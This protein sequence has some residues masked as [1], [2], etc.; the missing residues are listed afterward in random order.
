MD[1][2]SSIPIIS[3]ALYS[4]F[5]SCMSSEIFELTAQGD[6]RYFVHKDILARQSQPF[7]DATNGVWK[8]STDRQINL[9]DWDAK[10]VGRLVQ[11][12]YT[13]DYKYTTSDTEE[14]GEQPASVSPAISE[15]SELGAWPSRAPPRITDGTWL[16]RVDTSTFDF[17]ETLLAHAMVYS[18]AHY[19]AITALKALAQ[20][21]LLRVLVALHPMAGN[22]HLATNIVHL[23]TYVYGNTD[24]LTNS[25][26]PLRNM[27]TNYVVLNFPA[28]QAYPAAVEMMCG[29]GDFVR[30]VLA[31]ICKQLGSPIGLVM[32][33]PA[34]RFVTSIVWRPAKGNNT[35]PDPY[36]PELDSRTGEVKDG[37]SIGWLYP[38]FAVGHQTAV[39][40]FYLNQSGGISLAT[41][42]GMSC[43][44]SCHINR[45]VS[46]DAREGIVALAFVRCPDGVINM[47]RFRDYNGVLSHVDH[48]GNDAKTFYLLWKVARR[49]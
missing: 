11:F 18:L 22:P 47:G 13:G 19:K 8:E 23:A 7:T 30:D 37:D 45:G 44:S 38:V 3:N 40:H 1:K 17:E 49:V 21:R 32:A 9:R 25:A 48:G 24:S 15:L 35:R 33:T 29:G 2:Q 36:V 12:L 4:A 42:L 34:T 14:V 46:N 28:W 5:E 20:E 16:E 39:T 6:V 26:E 27:V 10:T 31:K 43:G 41:I